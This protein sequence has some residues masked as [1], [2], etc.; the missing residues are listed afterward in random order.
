MSD[1]LTAMLAAIPDSYQK[2]VG[3][4][5]YDILAA[6]DLRISDTQAQI[7]LAESKI[8]PYNLAGS[9]LDAYITP[10][11]GQTRKAATPAGGML[12]VTGN[13]TVHAGDLFESAGG[14]Q[15]AAEAD[16]VIAGS[17]NVPIRGTTPG[18]AGNVAAGSITMMP[19]Q[20]AGIV[21]VSNLDTL[22]GGYDAETD[23]AYFARFLARLRT[24]P[25]SGNRYHYLNWAL[26]VPGVGGAQ[27]YPL[28]HGAN[29]VDVVI[30]DAAGKPASAS[31][32]QTVQA[33]IDPGSTGT[34][35]GEAPLGAYCYVSAATGIALALSLTVTALPGADQAT[36]TQAIKDAVEGYLASIAFEADYVSYAKIAA[37]ILAATGVQDHS[38]L[39][40]NGGTANI[41]IA[42]RSVAILGEV[43]ITYAA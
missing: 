2:T 1:T 38:G 39:L 22:S 31:L 26:E 17:G 7:T 30:I 15:F 40:I 3:Y 9:E 5:T 36:V 12:Q 21:K 41:P 10:R 37:A 28:G 42:A 19:V 20:L 18:S 4:P 25:T 14:L 29:T 35:D 34:G 33:H 23:A 8:N 27:V 24:P 32:V 11:T 16:A 13:G 6:A 43:T